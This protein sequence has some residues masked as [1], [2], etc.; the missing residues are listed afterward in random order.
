[1]P[2]R[3]SLIRCTIGL[4]LVTIAV[5]RKEKSQQQQQQQQYNTI[6]APACYFFDFKASGSDFG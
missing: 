5:L 4:S 2:E 3:K 1:M 6:Q